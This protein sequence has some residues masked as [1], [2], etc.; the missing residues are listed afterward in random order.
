M[1]WGGVWLRPILVLSLSL[2]QAEQQS[3]LVLHP[4]EAQLNLQVGV[5][6]DKKYF[7]STQGHDIPSSHDL[8]TILFTSYPDNLHHVT[9]CRVNNV[10][11]LPMQLRNT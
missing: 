11:I 5:D 3:Q 1:G 9:L 7:P 4:T 6:F 2:G 8:Y 10:L